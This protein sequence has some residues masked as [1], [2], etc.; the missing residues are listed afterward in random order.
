MNP[1]L[2]CTEPYHAG[3]GRGVT[4]GLWC[5][6]HE[7]R[8]GSRVAVEGLARQASLFLTADIRPLQRVRLGVRSP[9]SLCPECSA[10]L[11]REHVCV[12]VGD[13]LLAFLRDA[14][15]AECIADIRTDGVPKESGICRA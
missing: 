15:I 13:P 1:P 7:V 10:V 12:E 5:D 8:F 6:Y 11:H 14:Q 9:G 2:L 3:R 4:T